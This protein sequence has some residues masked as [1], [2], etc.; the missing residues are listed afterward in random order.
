MVMCPAVSVIFCYS[1]GETLGNDDVCF[2][3]RC[4]WLKF[5][6]KGREFVMCVEVSLTFYYML[7]GDGIKW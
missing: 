1:V 2:N 4:L 6:E 3:Y 5:G 7:W